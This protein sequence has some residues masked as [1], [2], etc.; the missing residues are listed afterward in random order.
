MHFAWSIRPDTEL[1]YLVAPVD[2]SIGAALQ[3]TYVAIEHGEIKSQSKEP[4]VHTDLEGY[5]P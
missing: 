4:L 2:P 3:E 5:P 1:Q